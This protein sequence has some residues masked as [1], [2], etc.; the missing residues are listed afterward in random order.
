MQSIKIG[1]IED[2][3]DEM[4]DL[5]EDANEINDVSQMPECFCEHSTVDTH[6]RHCSFDD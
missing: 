2:C 3:M 5:L 1:E 4:S 6:Q